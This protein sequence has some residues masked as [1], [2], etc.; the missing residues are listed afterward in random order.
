MSAASSLRRFISTRTIPPRLS[1]RR[2]FDSTLV[3]FV[4]MAAVSS[5]PE[6]YPERISGAT[7]PGARQRLR[8][9]RSNATGEPCAARDARMPAGENSALMRAGDAEL[10]GLLERRLHDGVG[11]QRQRVLGDRAV[12]ARPLDRVLERAV[13]GH[14]AEGDFEVLL[15]R[16]AL[17]ERASPERALALGAAPEREHHRQG[18]LALAEIVA[19]VLAELGRLAAVVERVVDELKGD[20]Q[21]HAERAARG[22]V[23]LRPSGEPRPDL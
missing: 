6:T 10:D 20:A 15:R 8:R 23:L 12:M 14:Q 4:G 3:A 2:Y 19:D 9:R 5:F 1:R 22:R 16:V 21:I 7:Q 17:L 13:L 11:E 18:D